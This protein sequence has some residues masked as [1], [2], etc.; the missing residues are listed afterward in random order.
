[1]QYTSVGSIMKYIMH[2]NAIRRES[3]LKIGAGSEMSC[4]TINNLI[5]F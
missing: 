3:A 5:I 4:N 2:A 1:M